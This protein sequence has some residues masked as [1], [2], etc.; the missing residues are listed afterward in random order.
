METETAQQVEWR[1]VEAV[2]RPVLQVWV[3]GAEVEWAAHAW[4]ALGSAG[5]TTYSTELD[6]T[7][8]VLRAVALGALAR[9]FYAH[10]C[11]EG[12]PGDWQD[13]VTVDLVGPTP[14]ID[15]FNLGRLV[16]REGF[17]F[18]NLPYDDGVLREALVA[19]ASEEYPVVVRALRSAW[20]DDGLFAALFAS[21]RGGTSYPMSA[22]EISDVVNSHV[23]FAKMD[24][25]D[26]LTR[27]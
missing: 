4:D 14:L 7:R 5:L 11:D 22:E 1:D 20:G 3:F 19:L 15:A 10:A 23:S 6:R 24:A 13:Q 9:D 2:A 17:E 8:C 16:E 21:S 27:L 25:W 18:D 26:W 12:S